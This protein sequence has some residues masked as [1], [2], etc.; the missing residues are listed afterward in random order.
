M[1][2]VIQ[3]TIAVDFDGVIH[4]YRKAWHDGTI[5]DEPVD[6]ARDAIRLIKKKGFRV[7]VFTARPDLDGIREW[8]KKHNIKVDDVTNTKPG[9]VM[10][11]DDRAVRFTHWRDMLNYL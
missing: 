10:Y 7:V 8:L 6:G 4:K 3:K 2:E 11:I 9:A 5:Y 1:I